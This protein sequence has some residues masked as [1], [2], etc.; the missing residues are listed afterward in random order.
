MHRAGAGSGSLIRIPPSDSVPLSS[1]VRRLLD[2]AAMRR[3]AGI[4]QLGMVSLV[5][6]GAMHTR[7]EHTLGVYQNALR[8]LARFINDD[9]V[10]PWLDASSCDAFILASLA[11]D[12]GHWPFCHPI[13]DMQLVDI[14]DHEHRVEKILSES[15]LADCIDQDWECSIQDVVDLLVGNPNGSQR[16]RSDPRV[17]LSSCLSGPIDIDKLDYLQRDSLHCGVDYGRNFD[18]G[19][20]ISSLVADPNTKRLAVGEKGRTAA[21]MMVFARYI[22]FSEVYWHHAVRAA[23]AM[24][25][26]SV[27]LLHNRLDLP[28]TLKLGDDEWIALLR[29]AAEGSLAEP[30]VEG[31]F[32]SRRQ[33][34]KRVVEFSALSGETIHHRLARRPYWQLVALCEDVAQRLSRNYSVPV[35]ASDVLIDAPPVKLEVDINTTVL[36]SDGSVSTLGDVSP[37]AAVLA[38]EQ[39]DN[40]VKRVRVFV[41]A[42][43]RDT[44]REHLP[45]RD[46]W[47]ALLD[48]SINEAEQQWQ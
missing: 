22:M 42:D 31:L 11:H 40:V 47:T 20:L 4:S 16:R 7:L 26:R 37:V 17:F 28:A 15:E 48:D 19:R 14:P 43:L 8:F 34:F 3:L 44:L 29:R 25:Q 13:E 38:R 18:A 30:M 21:E 2:T 23:T 32:G 24:L 33:L 45:T 46:D 5:Y 12:L 27:F 35:A 39:F 1:R 41:R 10:G 6:P 36:M 9:M